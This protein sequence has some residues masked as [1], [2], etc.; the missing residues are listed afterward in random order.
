MK[1]VICAA[2]ILA[3]AGVAHAASST[4]VVAA[5]LDGSSVVSG[6]DPDGSGSFT[7][8]IDAGDGGFC[9]DLNINGVR[10]VGAAHIHE[11][12]E[13][14]PGRP[15]LDLVAGSHCSNTDAQALN[16]IVDN[17]SNYYIDVLSSDYPEGAVRG[18]LARAN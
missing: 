6:G 17:P 15:V 3:S 4:N 5:T 18:Q 9:Y 16:D 8:R 7:L 10:N 1:K 14:L 12:A 11:G 13:G 2:A